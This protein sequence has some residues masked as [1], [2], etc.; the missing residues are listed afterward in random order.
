MATS[1]FTGVRV[2]VKAAAAKANVSTAIVARR[3]KAPASSAP[4]SSWCVCAR[5]Q[6]RGC[7]LLVARGGSV[8]AR[9]GRGSSI[10]CLEGR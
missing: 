3:T 5:P 6:T 8:W 4:S 1:S 7:R 10:L 2:A 9:G